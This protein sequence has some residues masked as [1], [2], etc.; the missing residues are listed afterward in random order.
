MSEFEKRVSREMPIL[1]VGCGYGRTLSELHDA[2]YENLFGVDFSQGMIDRGCRLHPYLNLR[3]NDGSVLP[4]EDGA[5]DAV[6]LIA[7]LTCIAES[8]GQRRLI[9][10]IERVLKDGGILYINDYLLNT[11]Q[12]NVERYEKA[13]S[14]YGAYGIFELPEGAVVRHHTPEHI[15]DITSGFDRLAFETLVYTTMNGN[16]SNG[17]YYTGRKV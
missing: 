9:S 3:K 7:V 1:D 13:R 4:F 15:F 14:N 12:R 17:F 10:E 2:G 8:E 11:D 16:R 6:L 5:F